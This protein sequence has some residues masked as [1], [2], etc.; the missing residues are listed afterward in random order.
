MRRQR[1]WRP[2]PLLLLTAVVALA[3]ATALVYS[4]AASWVFAL[5]Q[6]QVVD[7]YYTSINTA[8]PSAAEQLDEARRYNAD[9]SAGAVLA[10]NT[11]VP[12]GDGVSR[13][14]LY[15]YWSMLSTSTGVMAR[16]QIPKIDV[17]LPIYHGTSEST[18][19]RGV[20]HLEGTSLPVGGESTHT[21]LTGH[22]GLAEARLFTDLD[23]LVIGDTFTV[24]TFGKVL[25]YKVVD[26]R[27]V[28]PDDTQ[29]LRQ[30]E[31]RDLVT[32]VTCTPLGVN[33]HRILVTGERVT[34]TPDEDLESATGPSDA[35]GFPWWLVAYVI[36]LTGIGWY[37]WRGGR[38][39]KPTPPRSGGDDH[40]D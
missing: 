4:S 1:R 27:V 26:T 29:A 12:E 19:Q 18:L 11:T 34:P 15:D 6:T 8:Q 10:A 33:T 22:R 23:R 3:G 7:R 38:R 40:D 24:N 25:T 13:N 14:Q 35:P 28:E 5:N 17:D 37:V 30:E 39:T 32:L 21:V 9:L 36:A 2:S 20:G 16:I 31:G